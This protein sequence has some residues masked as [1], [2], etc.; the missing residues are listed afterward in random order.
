MPLPHH[1]V[2]PAACW[3]GL[4]LTEHGSLPLVELCLMSALLQQQL[5]HIAVCSLV[6]CFRAFGIDTCLHT[7]NYAW[8]DTT[9]RQNSSKTF[10]CNVS[11]NQ[12]E[13]TW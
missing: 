12:V 7:C 6:H 1:Q 2:A 4:L 9:R 3:Q 11:L 8:N 5:Q 10:C 13:L